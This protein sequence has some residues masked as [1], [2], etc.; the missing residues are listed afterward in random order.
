[1]EQTPDTTTLQKR[2]GP[3]ATRVDWYLSHL[4]DEVSFLPPDVSHLA[5][6]GYYAKIKF[7]DGAYQCGLHVHADSRLKG[8]HALQCCGE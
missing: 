8:R 1:M 6:D 4:E 3:D 7:V 5:V 2:L